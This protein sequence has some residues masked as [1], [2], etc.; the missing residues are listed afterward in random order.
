M[1]AEATREGIE[2][3]VEDG[4]WTK[5]EWRATTLVFL[6]PINMANYKLG[7]SF[8]YV[9]KPN[10]APMSPKKSRPFLEES[11]PST[12]SLTFYDTSISALAIT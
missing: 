10:Q 7:S 2:D 9:Q 5:A 11:P 6:P 4:Q 1:G 8:I 3:E 12:F